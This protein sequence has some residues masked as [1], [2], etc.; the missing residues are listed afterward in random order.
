M[1]PKVWEE[2]VSNDVHG[3]SM[4]FLCMVLLTA[5]T[6]NGWIITVTLF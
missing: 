2:A 3:Y 5:A 6:S 4:L 1:S